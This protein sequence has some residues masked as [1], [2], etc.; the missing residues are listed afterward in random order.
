MPDSLPFVLLL[1]AVA[2][3][4]AVQAFAGGQAPR[5]V[6]G[7]VDHIV[8]AVPDLDAS[9]ADLERRL[10]VRAAPGGQHPG[11]GTRNALIG[12]GP[13]SYLEILAP[14][15]A[16][17]AP[18]GGRWF[19]VD[20][21]TP[22]RLTGWAAKATD[23]T[24]LAATAAQRGVPLGPVVA[25]SRQRPDGVA[26]KWTLTDPGVASGVTLAP[27]FIDWAASPHP[28]VTAPRGPVLE[29]LR[30]EHPRPELAREPLAA[31]GIDLPVDQ[32]A[33]PALVAVLRT[34]SGVVELR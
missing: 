28:A 33:R 20:P 3:T 12:L 21:K 27:F 1:G 32:G 26:L 11:R 29:S 22:A 13:D 24:R 15:P 2:A 5:G 25:G 14:D 18:A 9:V 31:L 30:A 34:V 19:G 23:L 4:C 8:Y 6:L 17:P 7:R 10:G 16:Q